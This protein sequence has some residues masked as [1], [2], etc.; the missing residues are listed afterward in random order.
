MAKVAIDT[1]QA[2]ANKLMDDAF[3]QT[4]IT[5]YLQNPSIL[6]RKRAE[7]ATINR[8]LG[9]QIVLDWLYEAL[10]ESVK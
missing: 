1:L 2:E 3:T 4:S 8:L 5:N 10:I 9:T 6:K 7:D